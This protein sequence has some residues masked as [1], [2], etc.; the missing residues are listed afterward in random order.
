MSFVQLR[1]FED[2]ISFDPLHNCP[3]L[4]FLSAVS[5]HASSFKWFRLEVPLNIMV[6]KGSSIAF[7]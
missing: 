7:F 2:G 4:F 1:E 3:I 5:L 6:S